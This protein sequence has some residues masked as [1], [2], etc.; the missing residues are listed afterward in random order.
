MPRFRIAWV[1]IFVAIAAL[2]FAAIR[3]FFVSGDV[4]L[5]VLGALPM[6]NILAVG[7]LIA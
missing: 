3:A 6:A 4:A 2:D 7:I 1:M 5:L